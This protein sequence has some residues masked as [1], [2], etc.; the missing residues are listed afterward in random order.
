M[1]PSHNRFL[2]LSCKIH[3]E[4]RPSLQLGYFGSADAWPL[5][6]L[7]ILSGLATLAPVCPRRLLT[8]G[9]AASKALLT[10]HSDAVSNSNWGI[11]WTFVLWSQRRHHHQTV[12]LFQQQLHTLTCTVCLNEVFTCFTVRI[13]LFYE[14]E[15]NDG[16]EKNLFS[17]ER[18]KEKLNVQI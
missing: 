12:L 5:S 7:I 17:E 11:L 3:E 16:T 10:W 18:V 4:G 2:F 8:S 9:C 6:F 14:V 15:Q 1:K 13:G